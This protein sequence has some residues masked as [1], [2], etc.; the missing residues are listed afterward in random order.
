MRTLAICLVVLVG[1][2]YLIYTQGLPRWEEH[3]A[4]Q[5]SNDQEVDASRRCVDEAEAVSREFAGEMRQFAQPPVDTDLWA[6]MLVRVSGQMTSA[7]RA[8]SCSTAAC[9]DALAAMLE[10]RGLVNDLDRFVRS[11]GPPVLD[12]PT[13]IERV[14]RLIA[15]ARGKV[16]TG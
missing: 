14:S 15:S 6:G 13:R 16:L 4:A 9:S 8:C 5:E 1:V 12:A 7:D 2:G 3:K 11:S 10:L